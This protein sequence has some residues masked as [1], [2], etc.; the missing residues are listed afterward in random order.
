VFE[1]TSYFRS[2]PRACQNAW[3]LGIDETYLGAGRGW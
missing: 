2:R 1:P 3:P